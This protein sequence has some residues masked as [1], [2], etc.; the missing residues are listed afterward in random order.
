MKCGGE[1]GQIIVMVAIYTRSLSNNVPPTLFL[2][3]VYFKTPQ[4]TVELLC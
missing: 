3:L 2:I 4:Q 1:K